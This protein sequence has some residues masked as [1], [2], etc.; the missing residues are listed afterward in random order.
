MA[1]FKVKIHGNIAALYSL[2]FLVAYSVLVALYEF[3][4]DAGIFVVCR[5][6]YL[7]RELCHN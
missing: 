2:S 1:Y 3:L 4:C 5:R 7:E 6:P